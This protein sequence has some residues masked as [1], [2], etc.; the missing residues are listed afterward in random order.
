LREDSGTDSEIR[1]AAA[2]VRVLAQISLLERIA[3]APEWDFVVS[4]TA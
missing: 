1:G 2:R 4:E 3:M